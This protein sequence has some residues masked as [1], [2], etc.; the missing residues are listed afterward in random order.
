MIDKQGKSLIEFR[1]YTEKYYGLKAFEKEV[2][3]AYGF[4]RIAIP[5]SIVKEDK[6]VLEFCVDAFH[7]I[8]VL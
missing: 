7:M 1:V 8:E 6:K 5:L 2:R 3:W 4:G